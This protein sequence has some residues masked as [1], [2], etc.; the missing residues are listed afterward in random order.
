MWSRAKSCD[1][2][3]RSL[4]AC[5]SSAC[6]FEI[7]QRIAAI[8]E[9]LRY[10]STSCFDLHR[11][12][13]RPLPHI[14]SFT[15]MKSVRMLLTAALFSLSAQAFATSSR[16]SPRAF[17]LGKALSSGVS[18]SRTNTVRMMSSVAP[19]DFIKTEN[20]ANKGM[21]SFCLSCEPEP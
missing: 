9:D 7:D 14:A 4:R 8:I 17:G 1:A 18:T 16:R 2:D 19:A 10:P 20:E 11:V 12:L 15:K 3:T 21:F 13:T 6:D 5:Y